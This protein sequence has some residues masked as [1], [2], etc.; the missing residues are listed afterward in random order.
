M[1]S[2]KENCPNKSSLKNFQNSLPFR[3][4]YVKYLEKNS[5]AIG[6]VYS[7]SFRFLCQF[8]MKASCDTQ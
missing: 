1:K 7:Y 5:I 3:K 6:I 4:I 2:I 8:A